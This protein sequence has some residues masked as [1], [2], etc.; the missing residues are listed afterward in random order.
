MMNM[1]MLECGRRAKQD[2]LAI[3]EKHIHSANLYAYIYIYIYIDLS[4]H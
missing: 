1:N 3:H 4:V 2:R